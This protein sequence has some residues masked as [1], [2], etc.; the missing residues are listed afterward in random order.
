MGMALN[1]SLDLTWQEYAMPDASGAVQLAR[2][3]SLA[4]DHFWALVQFPRIGAAFDQGITAWMKI[5]CC[6]MAT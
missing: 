5:F 6:C 2:L 3:P 4:S 1:P